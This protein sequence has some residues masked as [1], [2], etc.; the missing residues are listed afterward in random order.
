MCILP[1]RQTL[2]LETPIILVL[3]ISVICDIGQLL[4]TDRHGDGL[5]KAAKSLL[6]DEQSPKRR[7]IL[8]DLLLNLEDRSE[9][10]SR[11]EDEGWF[12]GRSQN[13]TVGVLV[14][15]ILKLGLHHFS[16]SYYIKAGIRVNREMEK[17]E[18]QRRDC[19]TAINTKTLVICS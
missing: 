11:D 18:L 14:T 6:Y 7:K 10:E 3:L 5:I 4:S 19:S 2:E 17:Y 12:Q 13:V 9:L 15:L 1:V 16:G 8:T